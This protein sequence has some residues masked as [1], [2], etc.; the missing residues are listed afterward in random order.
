MSGHLILRSCL[1]L[2]VIPATPR[3]GHI[4]SWLDGSQ[5]FRLQLYCMLSGQR[6]SE[7]CRNMGLRRGYGKTEEWQ[8]ADTPAAS[9]L[10]L[11][12]SALLLCASMKLGRFPQTRAVQL[13]VGV[14]DGAKAGRKTP[15]SKWSF[16]TQPSS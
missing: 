9:L 13:C 4:A 10:F 15:S 8:G 12:V 7:L 3:S 5:P 14:E 2:P 11:T 6:M 1:Y 16:I